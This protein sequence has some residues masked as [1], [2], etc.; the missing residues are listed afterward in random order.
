MPLSAVDNNKNINDYLKQDRSVNIQQEL[1]KNEKLNESGLQDVEIRSRPHQLG[2]DDFLKLLVTQLTH[3]D[4]TEPMKDQQFIAQM[5]QFSSLEQMQNISGGISKL[6]DRQSLDLV[7]KYVVGTDQNNQT[8]SGVAEALYIEGNGATYLKIGENAVS[9][10][11]V[12]LVGK[13]ESFKKEFGGTSDES[14]I[15]QAHPLENLG[16]TPINPA[17]DPELNKTVKPEIDIQN[18]KEIE[19]STTEKS[20][21]GAFFFDENII[22]RAGK[23]Y[24]A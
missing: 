9:V 22:D 13:P 6:S 18:N 2:K 3:Q 23:R 11:N 21:K 7:G 5:A 14:S 12:K 15:Q 1:T 17:I 16:S 24:S 20:K 8:V 19:K 4:P 10:D